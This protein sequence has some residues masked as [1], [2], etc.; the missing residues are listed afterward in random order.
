MFHEPLM[1]VEAKKEEPEESKDDRGF[2]LFD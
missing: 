2:G 1:K